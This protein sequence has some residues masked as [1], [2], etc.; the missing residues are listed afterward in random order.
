MLLVIGVCDELPDIPDFEELYGNRIHH[1]PYCDGW[2][3]RGT[4]VGILGAGEK[5]NLLAL[6]LTGWSRELVVFTNGANKLTPSL[7]SAPTTAGAEIFTSP[8]DSIS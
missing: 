7:E 4:R 3:R 5:V 2:D 8:I 6:K 1:C